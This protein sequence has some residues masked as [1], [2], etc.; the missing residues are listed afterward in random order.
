MPLRNAS[1]FVMPSSSQYRRSL[2]SV[3]SSVR[4]LYLISLGFAALSLPI[5]F[6]QPRHRSQL[7]FPSNSSSE[8]M[9][10]SMCE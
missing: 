4:I 8:I 5:F 6:K 3:P 9:S 7:Y 2:L 10:P 1:L